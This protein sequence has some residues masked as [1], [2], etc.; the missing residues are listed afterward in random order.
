M[1]W[2]P[3]APAFFANKVF[4]EGITNLATSK[5]KKSERIFEYSKKL[6]DMKGIPFL[7]K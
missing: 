1:Q 2:T 5:T 6:D 3:E 7:P 4:S